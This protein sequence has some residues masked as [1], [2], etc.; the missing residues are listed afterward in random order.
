MPCAVKCEAKGAFCHIIFCAYKQNVDIDKMPEV[1]RYYVKSSSF[2]FKQILTVGY[3]I[4]RH[5]TPFSF[6]D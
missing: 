2:C 5:L 3:I 4:V 6:T 1:K